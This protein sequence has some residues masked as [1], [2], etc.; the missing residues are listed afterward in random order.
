M[1][2]KPG[3][4]KFLP[5][6]RSD[7]AAEFLESVAGGV[8]KNLKTP[9][10]VLALLPPKQPVIAA[11]LSIL[12]GVGQLYIG[13][14]KKGAT[15]L[16]L[17]IAVYP[18]AIVIIP[19][20]ILDAYI[21][22]QRLRQGRAIE[23]W[24]CFWQRKFPAGSVWRVSEIVKKGRA[25]QAI[26]GVEERVIDNSRSGST[27]T[28][29]LTVSRE[30]SC[31]Y[32]VEHQRE[33]RTTDTSTIRVREGVTRNRSVEDALRDKFAYTH[34]A[35]QVYQENLEVTIPPFKKMRVILHW[36]NILEVGDMVL[37][38]Q[39]GTTVQLPFAIVIGV[40]FDQTQ[41]DE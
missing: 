36:K 20:G 10:E 30:W 35:R 22:T 23:P 38:D 40:T 19:L 26:P 11:L 12:P 6:A 24:E 31:T 15:M 3:L 25:Q 17:S 37:R 14:K 41:I 33:H 13:Q 8:K 18:T 9:A 16:L 2:L 32:S 4:W 29:T 1:K 21:L 28:K 27:V 7:K 39:H 34:G 5:I